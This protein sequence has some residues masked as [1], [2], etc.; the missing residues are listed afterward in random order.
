MTVIIAKNQTA[1]NLFLNQL[2]VTDRI[3]PASGQ[4]TLTAYNSVEEIQKDTE[5]LA[6]IN[7]DQVLLNQDGVDFTKAQSLHLMED[8][9][10]KLNLT[11]VVDPTA[12]DDANAGYRR[13]SIWV[14]TLTPKAFTC[15]SDAATAAAWRASAEDDTELADRTGVDISFFTANSPYIEIATITPVVIA[16]FWYLGTGVHSP[17]TMRIIA[18]RNGAID[19]SVIDIYD[20]THG[21][22]VATITYTAAALGEYQDTTLENL[23]PH[24]SRMAVRAYKSSVQ[25]S[26]TQIHFVSFR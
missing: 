4:V 18:S 23:S 11:A 15:V 17:T 8:I 22:V 26:K 7:G 14:N 2:A 10:P 5:L 12:T 13:G 3:I 6:Y 19:E 21:L 24:S 20:E 25:A 16:R 9:R 1:V